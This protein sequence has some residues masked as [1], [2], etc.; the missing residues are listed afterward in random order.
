MFNKL[1]IDSPYETYDFM[2]KH[3]GTLKNVPGLSCEIGLRRGGGTQFICDSFIDN[4]DKRVHVCMDPYG[5]ILYSDIAGV[6]RS[7]Y[8]DVMKNE[9]LAE[10]FK[11]ASQKNINILFYNMED[12]EFYKRFSDGV[13]VYDKEKYIINI[14]CFVHIDGQHDR[15]SVIEAANFFI[16]RTCKGGL[17]VFDNTD[18]YD[19]T[20]VDTMLITN[21]YVLIDECFHKKIYKRV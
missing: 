17:L 20:D 1:Q 6:H 18:H 8:T 12:G 2:R 14:Y 21:G 4:D 7:D 11:Y 3:I 5:D 13:P 16:T 9:T 10:L 15:D 19:H